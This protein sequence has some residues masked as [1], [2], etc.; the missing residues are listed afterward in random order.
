MRPCSLQSALLRCVS[1]TAQARTGEH[2]LRRAL[3]SGAGSRRGRRGSSRGAPAGVRSAPACERGGSGAHGRA[4]RAAGEADERARAAA[5]TTMD[6]SHF[7]PSAFCSFL[8]ALLRASTRFRGKKLFLRRA[9]SFSVDFLSVLNF[10]LRGA[11]LNVD[12]NDLIIAV[13]TDR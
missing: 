4:A 11:L 6:A 7:S 12:G 2:R 1:V 13:G 3:A 10:C 9:L 8:G 5:I